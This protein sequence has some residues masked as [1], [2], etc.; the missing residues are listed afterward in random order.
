V[1]RFRHTPAQPVLDLL[2]R[3]ELQAPAPNPPQRACDLFVDEVAAAPQRFAASVGGSANRCTWS[4]LR[5]GSV[6]SAG[7]E[8][9]FRPERSFNVSRTRE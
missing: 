3:Y 5:M 8:F 9:Q 4:D 7:T 1:S 6:I 2:D